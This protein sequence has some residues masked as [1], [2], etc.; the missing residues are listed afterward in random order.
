MAQEA[1]V[2]VGHRVEVHSAAVQEVQL[3]G[4]PQVQE[5]TPLA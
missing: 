3:H 2:T 5:V 1:V 4:V